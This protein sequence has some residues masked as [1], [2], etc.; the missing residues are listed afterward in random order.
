MSSIYTFIHEITILSIFGFIVLGWSH[1]A[2]ALPYSP[3]IYTCKISDVIYKND[4]QLMMHDPPTH[5]RLMPSRYVEVVQA[6]RGYN[7]SKTLLVAYNG[8]YYYRAGIG[9][10]IGI[11]VIVPVISAIT[12]MSLANAFDVFSIFVVTLS[13]LTG[14]IGF[15][16]LY[17]KPFT[18]WIGIAAFSCLTIVQL[19]AGD[20]YLFQS[21][22]LIAGI[23]WIIYF[24]TK[25]NWLWL[26]I[27][28]T[29]LSF[30]CVWFSLIRINTNI[31][32]IGFI[33]VVLIGRYPFRK[34]LLPL[35]LVA[36]A[37]IPPISIE[38]YAFSRRNIFLSKS[39]DN[40]ITEDHHAIWHSIYCGLGFV[41]NSEVPRF[42]D[43]IAIDKV[44]SIDPS[45]P[46]LSIKY[47]E[48]LRNEVL[49]IALHKPS[50]LIMNLVAKIG[51]IGLISLI[52]LLPVVKYLFQKK[53]TLWFDGA[54]A[55]TIVLSAANGI[56]V[57][58]RA[59]YLLTYFCLIFLYTIMKWCYYYQSIPDKTANVAMAN[60]DE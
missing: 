26:C 41:R 9:D 25:Y 23:P 31:L 55:L 10:D 60:P 29:L 57:M 14:Y 12:G 58:P 13:S 17:P 38:R 53:V 59:K 45:A 39:G 6:A 32:G 37:C 30:I 7:C 28:V 16:Y 49:W 42:D 36:L 8:H 54:F 18:R 34:A 22:P 51:I 5:I 20:V 15:Y 27:S 50:I 44:R 2:M 52:F 21:S 43:Q 48:I 56:L 33:A 24:V 35:S 47:E 4:A 46:Y 40:V 1:V 19:I 3:N 11:T